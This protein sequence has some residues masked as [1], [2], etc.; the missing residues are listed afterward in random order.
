MALKC[1]NTLP[2]M[3]VCIVAYI[4]DIHVPYLCVW[5]CACVPS[6]KMATDL[7]CVRGRWE[8]RYDG[9]EG[10]PRGRPWPPLV[11]GLLVGGLLLWLLVGPL[12]WVRLL[13][14]KWLLRLVLCWWLMGLLRCGLL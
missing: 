7:D 10:T 6:A 5:V 12:L 11:G 8:G 3:H 14:V 9:G 13:W 1:P 2:S 4:S